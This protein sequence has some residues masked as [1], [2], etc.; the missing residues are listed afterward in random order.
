MFL[1]VSVD[2]LATTISLY[3]RAS[4][5]AIGNLPL[6][7]LQLGTFRY[8]MAALEKWS[9]CEGGGAMDNDLLP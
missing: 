1:M 7:F 6:C 8:N 3:T 4:Q 5:R 9:S 2:K